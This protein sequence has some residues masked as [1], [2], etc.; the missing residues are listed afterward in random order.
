MTSLNT[1]ENSQL[2]VMST[3]AWPVPYYQRAFRDPTNVDK[4]DGNLEMVAQPV[5]DF[6][7]VV[8]KE[9][10][11]LQGN[12]YVVEAL[13]QQYDITSYITKFESSAKF[14]QAYT[15]DLLDCLGVAQSENS[16]LLDEHDYSDVFN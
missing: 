5:S 11:M 14:S 8:A 13:E 10:L 2:R 7:V 12:G 9:L 6:H 16:R 4:V 1:G 15:D 3:P